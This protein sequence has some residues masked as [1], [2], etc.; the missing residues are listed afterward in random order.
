MG[1]SG[2][3]RL[4]KIIDDAIESN[5]TVV[6][7]KE[8]YGRFDGKFTKV[9]ERF[10]RVD[11]RFTKVDERFDRIDERFTKVD[12]R[13]DQMDKRFDRMDRRFDRMD[14]RFGRV[15]NRL[16]RLESSSLRY[17]ILQEEMDAKLDTLIELVTNPIKKTEDI[18]KI[19][20][21][22]ED[23]EVRVSA[24]EYTVKAK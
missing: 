15:D 16:E 14:E 21:K 4:S 22:I 19:I 12:E 5:A 1:K 18:P 8:G 11:E 13:F 23:H 3:T 2:K 20:D 24:L 17:G 7:L 10:D 6:F 9:G